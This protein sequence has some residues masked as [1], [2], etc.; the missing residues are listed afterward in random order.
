MTRALALAFALA[1]T[2]PNAP[3]R[4]QEPAPEPD[5]EAND[6]PDPTLP[7]TLLPRSGQDGFGPGIRWGSGWGRF[8]LVDYT[9]LGVG[10]AATITLQIIGPDA[11]GRWLRTNA[12]D[13]RVRGTLRA[14]SLQRQQNLRDASDITL[15]L[16]IGFPIFFDAILTALWFHDNPDV[17]RELALLAIEAQL[18]SSTLQAAANIMGSRERPY[19]RNCVDFEGDLPVDATGNPLEGDND[20][21]GRARYRS[22]YSGHTSQAF[23]AAATTCAVHRR[24]P[25]YGRGR[26]WLACA[27]ATSL[28]ATTGLLRIAGDKHYASDVIFGALTGTAIGWMLPALRMRPHPRRQGESLTLRVVPMGI[29]LGVLGMY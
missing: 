2:L 7:E 27:A 23:A 8:R 15:N 24:L 18:V 5:A 17:G 14:R 3:A 13:E 16:A 19:G 22:F 11:N 1:A 26:D 4:A 10:A 29:G 6:A 9:I 12:F 20:C 28:A 25:L 21:L